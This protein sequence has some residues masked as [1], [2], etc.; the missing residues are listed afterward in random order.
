[1]PQSI[2]ITGASSGI[3]AALACEYSG[4]GVLLALT[5]RDTSRLAAVAETCRKKHADVMAEPID[6]TEGAAMAQFLERAHARRPLDLVIANAG[7]GAGRGET[8][9]QVRRIFAINVDGVV[10]TV[11][12]AIEKMLTKAPDAAGRR[13]QIAIMSSLAG[14]HGFPGA[15]A[16]CASKAAV[17]VWGESLRSELH[18]RGIRVSVICPGFVR[19]RMSERNKFRMPLLMDADRAARIIRRGLS[20]NRARIAFPRR[21]YGPVALISALPASW[22]DPLFRRVTKKFAKSL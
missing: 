1:M 5:G 4:P 16:Y 22:L 9:E 15:P 6:V 3:G 10:N 19:S 13:G 17:K 21:I 8:I 12:P 2:V 18:G 11:V 7:I 20:R 14:F